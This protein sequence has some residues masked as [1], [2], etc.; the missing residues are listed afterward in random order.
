[1]PVHTLPVCIVPRNSTRTADDSRKSKARRVRAECQ[2]QRQQAF[3]LISSPFSPCVFL[4]EFGLAAGH[5]MAPPSGLNALCGTV[6]HR[7]RRTFVPFTTVVPV[8]AKHRKTAKGT[9]RSH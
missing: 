6:K 8:A 5:E 9:L 4:D 1:M 3:L 7:V 2:G